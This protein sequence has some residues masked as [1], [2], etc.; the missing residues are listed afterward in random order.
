MGYFL[1]LKVSAQH[2]HFKLHK[3]LRLP[4]NLHFIC[5]LVS[6]R[7]G[8]ILEIIKLEKEHKKSAQK[9]TSKTKSNQESKKTKQM[10]PKKH[11]QNTEDSLERPGR[12]STGQGSFLVPGQVLHFWSLF[13]SGAGLNISTFGRIFLAPGQKSH[14]W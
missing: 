5:N 3:A 8:L 9:S 10:Q 13:F 6:T 12:V 11:K 4:G 7:G 1:V 2:L 14:F